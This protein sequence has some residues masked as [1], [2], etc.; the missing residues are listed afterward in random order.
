MASGELDH[1]VYVS[2]YDPAEITNDDLRRLFEKYGEVLR[3]DYK[4]TFSFVIMRNGH[5]EAIEALDR[6]EIGAARQLLEVNLAHPNTITRIREQERLERAENDPNE[7][8]F[9][10]NYDVSTTNED[11][12]RALFSRFGNIRRVE[13]KA[14]FCFLVYERLDDAVRAKTEMDGYKM[15]QSTMKY[16]YEKC[17]PTF[18]TKRKQY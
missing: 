17:F 15:I 4:G 6:S 11:T 18:K 5:E 13:M 7:T 16:I 1:R 14:K 9:I 2:G 3:V 10:V 8:L 12:I